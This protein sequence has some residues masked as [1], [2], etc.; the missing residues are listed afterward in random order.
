MARSV[1]VFDSFLAMI[2]AA[3]VVASLAPCRAAVAAGFHAVAV[4]AVVVLFF[5]H[6][7]KLSREAIVAG[8][9][10]WRLHLL[11][12]TATFVVFP[13]G[14]LALRPIGVRL[15]GAELYEGVIFLCAL[16]ATVQSAIVFTSIAGGNVP[17]AICSASLSTL[18]G[19]VLTP[20]VLGVTGSHR[21]SGSMALTGVRDVALQ[22]LLPFL[23]GHMTRRW[24]A[25]LL[26]RRATLVSL[27]D[28]GTIVLVV[29]VAFSDA[30]V[31]HLWRRVSA[32]ELAG[33]ALVC[34]VLLGA[35]LLFTR[36]AS[37]L[38]G[39]PRED[40]IAIVFGGSKKSLASGIAMA[41]VLFTGPLVGVIVLPLMLFHQMQLM[42][43]TLLARRYARAVHEAPRDEERGA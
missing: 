30:V 24:L 11:V 3:V 25:P 28:R 21:E 31:Q 12:L 35:A 38:L 33:L 23:A 29:Y 27:V 13:L 34:A 43:C 9:G 42:A 18:L 6:G 16:P 36:T 19:V 41:N 10:H 14:G 39:F 1:K 15:V 17:A 7:A 40:E 22:I 20:L 5:L 37:R 26:A 4:A 8:I 32:S 2:L